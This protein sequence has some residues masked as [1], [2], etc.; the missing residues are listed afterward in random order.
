M[1]DRGRDRSE[2]SVRRPVEVVGMPV[3]QVRWAIPMMGTLTTV[4]ITTVVI[5]L[6][7]SS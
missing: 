5:L 7:Y 2:G 6:S 4:V 1:V 3:G